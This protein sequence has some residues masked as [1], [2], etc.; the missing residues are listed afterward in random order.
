MAR[1]N[2]KTNTARKLK[3][4]SNFVS[5]NVEMLECR[6]F[7]SAAPW[8]AQDQQIGLDL[9]T[10]NH[11]AITGAGETVAIIDQGVDYNHPA[12]GGGYGNKI[13]TSWNFDTGSYDTFPNDG[14]AHGT[15]TAGQIAADP[16][17]VDGLLYQG[18]A[19]GVKIISLRASGTYNVQ[20][21]L[22]WIISHRTQYNIVGLNY[23]DQSGADETQFVGQLQ[24]LHDSGVFIAGAVGNY[25]PGPAYAHM[26]D[27]IHTVGS[28]NSS[29]QLSSFTPR[30]SALDL[31]APGE[32]VGVTWYYDGIHADLPS[33]G[34]SW[35]APQVTG[36]AAL[37]KQINPRFS[38]DQVYQIIRDSA[39]SVYDSYSNA[40]YARLNVDGALTLAYQRSGQAKSASVAVTASRAAAVVTPAKAAPAIVRAPAVVAKPKAAIATPQ[41]VRVVAKATVV[42]PANPAQE[43]PF[44]GTP[45][46]TSTRIA[47]ANYDNGGEGIAYHDTTPF[48]ESG[49]AYRNGAVD[50]TWSASQ[51]TEI[52]GWTHAGEWM[53]YTVNV[54]KSGTYAFAAQTAAIGSGGKF[55]V[56]VD[57]KRATGSLAVN[58]TGGWDNYTTQVVK[59]LKLKAGKHVFRVVMDQNGTSGNVGNFNWFSVA[60]ASAFAAVPA[61]KK[62]R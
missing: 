40:N 31:V 44:T 34:T 9:A 46:A 27:L 4:A 60:P 20:Q 3:T 33:S 32:N 37:I 56:E 48:N 55:H 30:G 25:G 16:H 18:V 54:A 45:F 53:K 39:T 1:N 59:G 28:V 29:D 50:T 42:A 2:T 43:S 38:A 57:G 23:L 36:A 11:P 22:N 62:K 6:Q 17:V 35:T 51:N 21:A 5:F 8:S 49:D 58:N 12:L 13:V 7:L 47:A 10:Q 19:P 26:N 41:A 15:G 61:A 24:T 52:V 14:N